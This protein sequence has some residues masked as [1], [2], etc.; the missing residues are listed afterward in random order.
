MRGV[1]PYCDGGEEDS[2]GPCHKGATDKYRENA[3]G[4]AIDEQVTWVDHDSMASTSNDTIH[5]GCN[6]KEK[7]NSIY[8]SYVALRHL[9]PRKIC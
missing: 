1:R 3:Q 4:S 9:V 7:H 2:H 6:V 8:A 5:T